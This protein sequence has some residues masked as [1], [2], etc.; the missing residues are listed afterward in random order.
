VNSDPTPKQFR[1][2][3]LQAFCALLSGL[4]PDSGAVQRGGGTTSKNSAPCGPNEVYDK[5]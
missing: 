4:A 3:S 2:T 1:I 5:A